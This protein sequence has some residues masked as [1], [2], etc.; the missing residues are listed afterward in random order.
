[1]E[2]LIKYRYLYDSLC[3]FDFGEDEELEPLGELLHCDDEEELIGLQAAFFRSLGKL[4]LRQLIT[5]KILTDDNIFARACCARTVGSLPIGIIDAVRT[6]LK[7]LEKLASFTPQTV[8]DWCDD[9]EVREILLSMPWWETGDASPPLMKSWDKRLDVLEEHYRKNGYGIFA[10]YKTLKY[11]DE[12]LEG[13]ANP[14]AVTPDMIKG[15]DAQMKALAEN[16]EALLEGKPSCN[17]LLIGGAVVR[18]AVSAVQSRYCGEGLRLIEVARSDYAYLNALIKELSDSPLK[19]IIFLDSLSFGQ[20][21]GAFDDIKGSLAGGKE[22]VL[23]YAAADAGSD[24]GSA[25][26]FFDITVNFAGT[27]GE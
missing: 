18:R 14:D 17:I 21:D 9:D 2:D 10:E 3:V 7:K 23:I 24:Y 1:M 25:N 27:D 6:D 26:D 20:G 11:I 4:S 13:I 5:K 12:E 16:T 22:N 15:C 19:F 8:L